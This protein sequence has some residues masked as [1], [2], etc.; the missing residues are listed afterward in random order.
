MTG[1]PPWL[2]LIYID[3]LFSRKQLKVYRHAA[4]QRLLIQQSYSVLP[5]ELRPDAGKGLC[6][7]RCAKSRNQRVKS[8]ISSS[9]HRN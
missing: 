5:I 9:R 6:D 1:A 4:R 8:Q 7:Q 2:L 3:T